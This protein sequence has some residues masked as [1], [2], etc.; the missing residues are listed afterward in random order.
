MVDKYLT[1]QINQTKVNDYVKKL[2][3]NRNL[4]NNCK[5]LYVLNTRVM[6]FATTKRPNIHLTKKLTKKGIFQNRSNCFFVSLNT[7]RIYHCFHYLDFYC[8]F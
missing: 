7:L 6:N 4:I 3:F 1:C 5:V 8:K 2:I